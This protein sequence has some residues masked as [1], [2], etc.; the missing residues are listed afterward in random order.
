M[1]SKIQS[2]IQILGIV[3]CVVEAAPQPVPSDH[4]DSL[5]QYPGIKFIKASPSTTASTLSDRRAV[6]SRF[7]NTETWAPIHAYQGPV[8]PGRPHSAA[9]TLS[10]LKRDDV[11]GSHRSYENVT[12]SSANGLQYSVEVAFNQ[13]R[14][15]LNLDTGSADTWAVSS[16]LNCTPSWMESRRCL[17]GPGYTGGFNTVNAPSEH[18]YVE[19]G[20]GEQVQGPMGTVDV[21]IAGIRVV[22]QTVGLANTTQWIGNNITSGLLGL[23]YP[24][25]TNAFIGSMDEHEQDYGVK[26]SPIFAN[27]VKQGLV[28]DWF[29]LALDRNGSGG[30]LGFGGVPD[31]IKG[32]D[33]STTAITD[34]IIVGYFFGPS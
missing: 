33:Y 11:D 10:R 34:I 23:A 30:A 19:Y 17:F 5:M 16:H 4:D 21:D 14:L 25:L 15:L 28:D 32:V 20:D 9:A 12:E 31:H 22:N 3:A 26:Y 18:M 24:S 1:Q 8:K 13:Q 6:K 2:I 27:M 7:Q 29:S